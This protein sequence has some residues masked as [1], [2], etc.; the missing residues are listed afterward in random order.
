MLMFGNDDACCLTQFLKYDPKSD[1]CKFIAHFLHLT[2]L[3]A[4]TG[5]C[6][7]LSW[8]FMD[9]KCHSQYEGTVN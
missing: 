5:R 4:K 1:S 7:I 2:S 8:V 6:N 3:K 9:T